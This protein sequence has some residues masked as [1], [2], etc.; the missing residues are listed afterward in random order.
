LISVLF[1]ARAIP[2]AS[3]V[4]RVLDLLRAIGQVHELVG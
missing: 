3:G 1:E 2:F 4:R